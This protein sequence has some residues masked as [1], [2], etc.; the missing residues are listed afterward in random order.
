MSIKSRLAR[1]EAILPAHPLRIF[2]YTDGDELGTLDGVKM[3]LADFEAI[4]TPEDVFLRVVY[5]GRT[6]EQ[7]R[8]DR[9]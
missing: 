8:Q 5:D 9:Y 2:V 4:H 1:L 7:I 6:P 3:T